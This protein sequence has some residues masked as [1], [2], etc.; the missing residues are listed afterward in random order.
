[1]FSSRRDDSY[2]VSYPRWLPRFANPLC[3][4]YVQQ[5]FDRWTKGR[6]I[7]SVG[8]NAGAAELPFQNWRRFKEAFAPE[9]IREAVEASRIPVKNCLDPFGGSGTTALACQF[10]GV[11]PVTV[12]VNPFLA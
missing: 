11:E 8:T 7:R 12:E 10:L 5:H 2:P 6:T 3:C 4:T 1:M 9:L